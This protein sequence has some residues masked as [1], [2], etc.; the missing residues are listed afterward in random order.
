METPLSHGKRVSWRSCCNIYFW[1]KKQC[2]LGDDFMLLIRPISIDQHFTLP[3]SFHRSSYIFQVSSSRIP[4]HRFEGAKMCDP[5]INIWYRWIRFPTSCRIML[6]VL[7]CN[8]FYWH[9]FKTYPS[10]WTPL[11]VHSRDSEPHS[12]SEE[13]RSTRYPHWVQGIG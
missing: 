6:D 8:V 12:Y 11:P 1:E 5:T 9:K 4:K 3:P 2:A 7:R 13:S 10:G